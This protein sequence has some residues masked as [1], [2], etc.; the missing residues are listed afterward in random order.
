MKITFDGDRSEIF[1]AMEWM[2]SRGRQPSD[3]V[4]S[5]RM[6]ADQ[7]A[8]SAAKADSAARN[9]EMA[10]TDIKNRVETK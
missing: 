4:D 5:A 2:V 1:E 10:A 8:A 7:S 6:Y 3:L 9:A